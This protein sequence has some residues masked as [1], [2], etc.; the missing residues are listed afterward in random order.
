[1]YALALTQACCPAQTD[2]DL[3]DRTVGDVLREAAAHWIKVSEWP[4]PGSGK[5]RNSCYVIS[6]SRGAFDRSAGDDR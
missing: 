5:S 6:G 1:M 4:L 2:Q 3:H